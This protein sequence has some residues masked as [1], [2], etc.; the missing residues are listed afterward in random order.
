MAVVRFGT[1]RGY[2]AGTRTASLQVTGYLASMLVSVPVAENIDGA[3]V[4]DGARCVVVLNDGFN[5]A[6]A[7]VV[8][9][10]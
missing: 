5:P 9:V 8:A 3:L 1:I 2:D 7:V 6:D 4:V 10:Y